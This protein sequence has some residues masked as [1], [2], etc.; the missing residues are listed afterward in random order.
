MYL[1]LMLVLFAFLAGAFDGFNAMIYAGGA[2]V[3]APLPVL[4]CWL[5]PFISIAYVELP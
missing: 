1:G 4:S 3:G 5:A 2:C